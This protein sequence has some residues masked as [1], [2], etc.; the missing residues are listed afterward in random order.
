MPG[1]WQQFGVESA[2]FGYGGKEGQDLFDEACEP[3]GGGRP[4]RF[5]AAEE[6][7]GKRLVEERVFLYPGI[8]QSEQLGVPQVGGAEAG[9]G[10]AAGEP[11]RVTGVVDEVD[12]RAEAVVPEVAQNL[13]C[14]GPI[15]VPFF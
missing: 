11:A 2:G 9:V 7:C 12:D 8:A 1:F 13:I 3:A 10:E 6:Q 14:A 15:K 4:D 5:V